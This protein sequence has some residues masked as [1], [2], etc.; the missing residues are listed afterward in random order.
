[1]EEGRAQIELL[2]RYILGDVSEDEQRRVEELYFD[3][4]ELMHELSALRAELL[5]AWASRTLPEAQHKQL[6]RQ[7][8]K[9]PAL[10]QQ[11]EFALSLRVLFAAQPASPPSPQP[12]PSAPA[13]QPAL[14][15]AGAS[16]RSRWVSFVTSL[17][18]APLWVAAGLLLAFGLWYGLSAREKTKTPSTISAQL[19]E[20]PLAEK[21]VAVKPV[22]EK[23]VAAES[24]QVDTPQLAQTLPAPGSLPA[25]SGR[26]AQKTI[27]TFFLTAGLQRDYIAAPAITLPAATQLVQLQLEIGEETSARFTA[28]LQTMEGERLWEKSQLAAQRVQGTRMV[29]ARIPATLFKKQGYA[30]RL[31][32]IGDQTVPRT[33]YFKVSA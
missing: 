4:P 33:Y 12:H 6:E 16:V 1:M 31:I 23:P 14:A 3:N 19:A 29:I 22:A 11:A 17:Q 21:P 13:A 5:D 25:P 30:L 18:G 8:E 10:R 9:L 2:Q 26:P 27:A 7:L 28:I 24:P 15:A 20:K 32:P